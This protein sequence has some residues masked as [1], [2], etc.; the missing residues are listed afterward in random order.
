[1]QSNRRI[2]FS[3]RVYAR[4]LYLYPQEHRIEYGPS[5]LQVFTDQCRSAIQS[6]G[7]KGIFFLWLHTIIDLGISVF[8]EQIASPYASRGLLEAIPNVPLP[9]KG[10]ALVLVPGLIFFIGQVGQLTGQDWFYYLVY[11][12]AY[13]LII[14]V[15][16]VWWRTRKFPI[17]GLVP[18]GLFFRT[19][20]DFGY[21]LQSG[22]LDPSNPL[23][24]RLID[25]VTSYPYYFRIVMVVVILLTLILLCVLIARRQR[26][27]RSALVWMG[28][29]GFLFLFYLTA[30]YWIYDF[31]QGNLSDWKVFLINIA[32]SVFYEYAGFLLLILLGTFLAR[33]HGRLAMLLPMGYLLPIVLYGRFAN[34]WNSLPDQVVNSYLL[35]ISVTVLVYRFLI[36]LA[37]PLWIV[38]SASEQTQRKAS[39][40]TL[41]IVIGIQA[42]MNLGVGVFMYRYYQYTGWGTIEW[43][44]SISA[45]LVMAAGIAVALALYGKTAPAQAASEQIAFSTKTSED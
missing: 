12:A 45:Q 35:W 5:M 6:E 32:P 26:I 31:H 13:W 37:A 21:R 11:R 38:R 7:S 40:I 18:A 42:G 15:L 30:N 44:N 19:V 16:L 29:Y 24:A 28:I 10:V 34:I 41:L 8:K 23:W 43:Y 14:P 22:E 17:W 27:P 25:L 9:W 36:A 2:D 33:R 4:L 1:M 39:L 3:R 20:L